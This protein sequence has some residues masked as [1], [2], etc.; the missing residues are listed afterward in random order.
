MSKD[1]KGL[2]QPNIDTSEILI[3]SNK[4][5]CKLCG[6]GGA[7]SSTCP[8][9]PNA[10]NPNKY[11]HPL[12]SS[13]YEDIIDQLQKL[14]TSSSPNKDELGKELEELSNTSNE[15]S[16]ETP[17]LDE[18]AKELEELSN[19]G[20]EES[21]E[22][23]FLDE[24]E[25]ELI[26]HIDY[27]PSILKNF[28]LL[29]DIVR[30]KDEKAATFKI[31][32]YSNT[33]KLV[34]DYQGSINDLTTMEEILKDGGKK[35]PKT[36][37]LK[38]EEIMK[39]GTL[40]YIEKAKND[41]DIK[42]ILNFS[43]IYSIGPKKAKKIYEEYGI[44]EIDELQKLVDEGKIKLNNKEKIGLTYHYD[45]QKRIPYEEMLAYE[46]LLLD[47]AKAFDPSIE[48][49]ING[50]FRRKM[51]T[52][53]DID[54]LITGDNIDQ[55][56]K[57]FIQHLIQKKFIIETLADGKLKFMGI[58]K[59]PQYTIFRHIDIIETPRK[60]YPFAVL[61]FTGSGG[62]N[63]YMRGIALEK[64][65]SLNEHCLSYRKTKLCIEEDII[66]KKIGKKQFD[67]EQDIFMFLDMEYVLPENRNNIT[68]SKLV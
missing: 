68:I 34:T 57:K 27:K 1:I 44:S 56:R 41:A 14:L 21:I 6:S 39:T 33:I 8:L 9:N 25:K 7:N 63:S 50:S 43:K 20:N 22:T 67:T 45:L 66:E 3:Q 31:R 28:T 65:F 5:T 49:S 16:I 47:E 46:K 55:K 2:Y 54:V 24:L 38:V 17:F 42:A 48:L 60:E 40:S 19:T 29:I 37:L 13:D 61:Y 53:G 59:H 30:A 52:S 12:A 64:G 10:K 51:P 23:P 26:V 36:T 15:E 35:N 11:K 18:L 62:F 4:I 32:E 58:S